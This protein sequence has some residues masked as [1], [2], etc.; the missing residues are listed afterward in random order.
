MEGMNYEWRCDVV[1]YGSCGSLNP[2]ITY[3]EQEEA[4]S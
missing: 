3:A 2:R 4:E 1:I